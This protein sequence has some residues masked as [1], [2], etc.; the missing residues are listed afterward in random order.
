MNSTILSRLLKPVVLLPIRVA[1]KAAVLTL[2][3]IWFLAWS[4]LNSGVDESSSM[5]SSQSKKRMFNP[6]TGV[7]MLTEHMD[8]DGNLWP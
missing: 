6:H 3:G 2:R 1:F 5:P 8:I 4:F 7:I